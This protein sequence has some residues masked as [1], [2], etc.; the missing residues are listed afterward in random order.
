MDHPFAA[1]FVFS[2]V[3][4]PK[5][6]WITGAVDKLR[7]GGAIPSLL[8]SRDGRYGFFGY[9]TVWARMILW[10]DGSFSAIVG[11]AAAGA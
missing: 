8:R 1:A 9:P 3:V 11:R 5:P 6:L 4:Q 2:A 10:S 7:C